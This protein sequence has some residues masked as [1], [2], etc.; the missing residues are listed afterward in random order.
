MRKIYK[1]Y[2]DGDMV[3]DTDVIKKSCNDNSDG[4]DL[5]S[6][7]YDDSEFVFSWATDDPRLQPYTTMCQNCNTKY[8]SCSCG[9]SSGGKD[10]N[11]G[12][13]VKTKGYPKVLYSNVDDSVD[14]NYDSDVDVVAEHRED[15]LEHMTD[16]ATGIFIG[17]FIP[18]LCI[19]CIAFC[20]AY[21]RHEIISASSV[22]CIILFPYMY[23]TYAI[24]DG[25]VFSSK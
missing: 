16:N 17:V 12:Y 21:Y 15:K 13:P 5:D 20:I 1:D 19:V 22:A 14:Y 8:G 6:T 11:C 10:I 4:Y 23:I 25:V 3:V 24:V 7:N 2:D 18:Y 9:K